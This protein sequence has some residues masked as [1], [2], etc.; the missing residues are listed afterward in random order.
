MAINQ[1]RDFAAVDKFWNICDLELRHVR[2]YE[3]DFVWQQR[4]MCDLIA[5][6]SYE[7]T[8]EDHCFFFC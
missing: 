3:I 1:Q 5:N 2:Q 8:S 4:I 7:A 6:K